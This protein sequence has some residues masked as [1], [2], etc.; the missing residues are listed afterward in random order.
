MDGLLHLRTCD[1][2]RTGWERLP[3]NSS[4]L[5]AWVRSCKGLGRL[6]FSF[7]VLCEL[8]SLF[9]ASTTLLF[10]VIVTWRY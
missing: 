5:N 2:L 4:W 9:C 6:A 3:G 1:P 10:F 7:F 8:R